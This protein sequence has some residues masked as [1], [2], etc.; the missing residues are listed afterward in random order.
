M[1]DVSCRHVIGVTRCVAT[2]LKISHWLHLFVV[3]LCIC[4]TQRNY[5]HNIDDAKIAASL[6]SFKIMAT[7]IFILVI[8]VNHIF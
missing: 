2:N 5:R 6:I 4:Q 8:N 3:P 7:Y 1:L